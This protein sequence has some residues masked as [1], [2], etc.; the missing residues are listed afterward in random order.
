[1]VLR[2]YDTMHQYA[3]TYDIR[4]I[5]TEALNVTE[6]HSYGSHTNMV[7]PVTY[8]DHGCA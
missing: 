8:D 2:H 4:Y 3:F 1:V 6:E 7:P 5:Y